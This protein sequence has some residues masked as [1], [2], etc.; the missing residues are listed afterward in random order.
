MKRT[1][2]KWWYNPAAWFINNYRY[3]WDVGEAWSQASKQ[4]N[5]FSSLDGNN[6]VLI[7]SAEDIAFLISSYNIQKGDILY[8]VND[9]GIVGH[10][11]IITSVD[12]S[13]IYYAGHT[14]QRFNEPLSGHIS[15]G[16][17]YVVIIGS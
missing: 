7:S 14:E 3:D 17:V 1:E 12:S 10:A 4:Y 5:Y 15:E 8:F 13:M 16:G 11:A 9:Q 6:S 2:K